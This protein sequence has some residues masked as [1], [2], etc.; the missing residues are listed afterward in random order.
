MEVAYYNLSGGINLS[1]T[2]TEM[3]LDTKRM[4]WADAYNVELLKNNGIKRQNGNAIYCELPEKEEITALHE[5]S[6]NDDSKLI[7]ST[8]SGKVYLFDKTSKSFTLLS[9][10]LEGKKP[11]FRNFLNGFL[12]ISEA[13]TLHYVKNDAFYKK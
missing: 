2:K 3:G 5:F 12:V 8:I 7:I 9:L 1:S 10:T 6:Y 4:Y 13:D 11:I